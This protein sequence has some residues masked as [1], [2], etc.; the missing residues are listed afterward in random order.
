MWVHRRIRL[1]RCN[2][3]P[4][5]TCSHKERASPLPDWLSRVLLHVRTRLTQ[6]A[7]RRAAGGAQSLTDPATKRGTAC[8]GHFRGL[9]RGNRAGEPARAQGSRRQSGLRRAGPRQ[10]G[11]IAIPLAS[12]IPIVQTY[13]VP[14]QG[15]RWQLMRARRASGTTIQPIV[16]SATTRVVDATYPSDLPAPG[17]RG[18]ST[19]RMHLCGGAC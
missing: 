7:V 19:I 16:T 18:H 5:W 8:D 6:N 10:D 1:G 9:D 17:A 4:I 13:E 12:P 14:F 15:G 11:A 2:R 3:H